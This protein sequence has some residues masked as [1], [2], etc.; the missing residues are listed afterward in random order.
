MQT[1]DFLRRILPE[2]GLYVAARLTDKGFRNTICNSIEELAQQVQAA[3]AAGG[4]QIKLDLRTPPPT[5]V[6]QS[7]TH[8]D[9]VQAKIVVEPLLLRTRVLM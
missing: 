6:V 3:D 4:Q 2:H 8:A 9:D 7:R 5:V 1:V